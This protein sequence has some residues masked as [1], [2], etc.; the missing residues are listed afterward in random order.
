MQDQTFY[1]GV[2]VNYSPETIAQ[3]TRDAVESA[4]DHIRKIK[5]NGG[6]AHL[7]GRPYLYQ[8]GQGSNILQ[9]YT[10]KEQHQRVPREVV[11]AALIHFR[12]TDEEKAEYNRQVPCKIEKITDH[13][14]Y[15]SSHGK[16]NTRNTGASCGALGL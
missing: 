3:A 13:L 1:Q 12:A 6:T 8:T 14:W 7:V 16:N 10:Y 4:R 5:S 15:C 2:P 11:A 9:S